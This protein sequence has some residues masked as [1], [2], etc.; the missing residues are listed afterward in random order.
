MEHN[1][2]SGPVRSD[3]V[4][5]S[6]ATRVLGIL[7]GIGIVGVSIV[8]QRTM[9]WPPVVGGIITGLLA[10]LVGGSGTSVFSPQLASV[11]GWA[12]GVAFFT[13]IAMFFGALK[14]LQV[15]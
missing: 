1:T 14:F 15:P 2:H 3:H 9:G 8:L 7:I 13:S 5:E 6:A 11:Y 4:E 10:V 12:G